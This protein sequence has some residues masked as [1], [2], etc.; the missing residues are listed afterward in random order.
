MN[1]AAGVIEARPGDHRGSPGSSPRAALQPFEG[2]RPKDI[3]V[4]TIPHRLAKPMIVRHHYLHAWPAS[5]GLSFGLF[6]GQRLLGVIVLGSGPTNAHALVDQATHSDCLVISRV[7]LDDALP[8]NSE[9]RCLSIVARLLR[10]NTSIKFLLSYADPS[11][12][13]GGGIYAGA[14]WLYIGE[15]QATP[16]LDFGD[17]KARHSRS[18]AHVLGTHGLAYFHDRGIAVQ[19][20]PQSPKRRFIRFIDPAWQSKLLPPVL[21]YSAQGGLDEHR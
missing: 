6:A 3:R 17:G 4:Q 13:H 2:V 5:S 1:S 8:R 7:W 14:G 20:V 12:G 11:A 19:K 9:S 21:P 16:L 18:V 15:S 10:Q